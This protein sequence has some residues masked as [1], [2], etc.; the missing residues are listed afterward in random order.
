LFIN[1]YQAN[2]ELVFIIWSEKGTVQD[3][4]FDNDYDYDDICV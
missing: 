2:T 4:G 1:M 3:G